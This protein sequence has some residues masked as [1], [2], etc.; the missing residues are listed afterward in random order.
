[1]TPI[2][3]DLQRENTEDVVQDEHLSDQ[4]NGPPMVHVRHGENGQLPAEGEAWEDTD[5]NRNKL[6]VSNGKVLPFSLVKWGL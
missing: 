3:G 1:M 5:I 4:D 2:P 6:R